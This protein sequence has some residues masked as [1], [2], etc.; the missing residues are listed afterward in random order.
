M[1]NMFLRP[2]LNNFTMHANISQNAVLAA[3]AQKPYCETG[4]ILPFELTGL[5]VINHGQHLSY[6]STALSSANQTV[7]IDIAG[8]LKRDFNI[9]IACKV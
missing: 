2:G 1:D 9:T 5:D 3:L 4:G 6:Y 8:S 7:D